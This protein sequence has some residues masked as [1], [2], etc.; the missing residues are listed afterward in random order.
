MSAVTRTETVRKSTIVRLGTLVLYV[1]HS[2]A[3]NDWFCSVHAPTA[4]AI[5][6]RPIATGDGATEREALQAALDQLGKLQDEITSA[7]AELERT[8]EVLA[9]LGEK[10]LTR[11]DTLTLE[12]AA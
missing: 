11:D 3:T 9:L 1:D 5:H 2:S 10:P 6:T 8:A 12:G 7:L 4:H